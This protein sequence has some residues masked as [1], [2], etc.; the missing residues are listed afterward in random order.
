[1]QMVILLIDSNGRHSGRGDDHFGSCDAEVNNDNGERLVT[2]L[3]N[4]NLS[5]YN[6]FYEAGYTWRSAMIDPRD[7][8]W[9][10]ARTRR[11]WVGVRDAA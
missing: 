6:S 1:M 10:A 3:Q 4:P 7:I 2:L 8:G 9:F 5:A 11:Y